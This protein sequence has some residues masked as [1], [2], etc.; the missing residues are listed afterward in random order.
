MP[1]EFDDYEGVFDPQ[2]P[3]GSDERRITE[4]LGDNPSLGYTFEGVASE[5]DINKECVHYI[6]TELYD[7]Q[8][9]RYKPPYWA[10]GDDDRIGTYIGSILSIQSADDE[11]WGEWRK[12]AV[13]PRS[14]RESD[15]QHR[16]PL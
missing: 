9:V 16:T 7:R 8:L 14:E 13:D 1:V 11:D 10:I 12:Y 2:L 4:F 3:E 15:E 6:L 5:L